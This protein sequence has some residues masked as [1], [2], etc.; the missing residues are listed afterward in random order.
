[1]RFT[2]TPR[3]VF[4]FDSFEMLGGL[5]KVG[6]CVVESVLFLP[7]FFLEM[8]CGAVYLFTKRSP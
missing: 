7:V 5:M 6:G 4:G 1:M 2:P 3:L 8:G